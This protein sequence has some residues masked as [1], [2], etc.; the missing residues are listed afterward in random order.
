VLVVI[1]LMVMAQYAGILGMLLAPPLAAMI[2]ILGRELWFAPARQS[3]R[4]GPDRPAG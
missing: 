1:T 4:P 2:Q 3:R